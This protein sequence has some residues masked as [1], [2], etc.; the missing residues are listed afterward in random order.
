[1]IPPRSLCANAY[2]EW[3]LLTARTE[4]TDRMLIFNEPHLRPVLAEYARH[5]NGPRPHRSQGFAMPRT[6]ESVAAFS[7]ER[8]KRRRPSAAHQRISASRIEAQVK[9]S[10]RVL[11][12][13]RPR[14][15]IAWRTGEGDRRDGAPTQR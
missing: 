6:D 15:R 2:A 8:F 13:H 1:M 3:F 10:G 9:A 7:Q 11:V 5:C 4:V 12:P 14:G